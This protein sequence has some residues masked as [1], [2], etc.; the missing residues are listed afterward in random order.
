MSKTILLIDASH[1]LFRA[2][3][4]LP[5]LNTKSGHPTGATRGFLSMLRALRRDVPTDYVAC[6]FDPKGKTF[7]SDIYPDYKA[8]R[9]E[10]PEDL[11]LQI[12]DVFDAVRKQGIPLIQVNGIEADDTIGTIAKSAGE[13]GCK[14]VIATGDKDYAQLVTQDVVLINTMGA[15]N[16]W[17]DIEGVKEKFG[18]PPKQIIDYLALMGDKIDNVPGVPK[19]GKKTA[20][21]WLEEYGSLENIIEN[22]AAVKGKIG[23]NLRDS[24]AFLPV[25]KALVTIKQD[26]DISSQVNSLEDLKIKDPDVAALK[27]LYERLEFRAFLKDLKDE[28]KSGS[29]KTD[30]KKSEEDA[31]DG[32]DLFSNSE[33][34]EVQLAEFSQQTIE[35]PDEAK[36]LVEEI[37]S[38]SKEGKLP[39]LFV[40]ADFKDF[41]YTLRGIA[42]GWNTGKNWFVPVSTNWVD[43]QGIT[44][45]EFTQIFGSWLS[46]PAFEKSCYDTK[47]IAHVLADIGIEFNGI[48]EDV[49]LQNYVLEAHRTHYI[50]KLSY[51]WLKFELQAEEVLLGKGVKKKTFSEVDILSCAKFAMERSYVGAHLSDLFC[52][53]IEKDPNLQ[54]IYREIEM[55]TSRV[56]FRMEQNGVLIDKQLLAKQTAELQ[57]K[58][59]ELSKK[60]ETIAGEKFNLASPKQ[61]GEILFE[62]LGV[63]MNG[64]PS[65]K[66]ASGNYS[67]SEEVLSELA[68]DYPLAKIALEYR[69]LTK[70]ISTY[71]EK[72]PTQI[73]PRDGRVHTTFEQAV[74]VTGRLS[75]TNPNL[76]NI[77]VRTPEGRRVREAFIAGPGKK[78]ISAD[79][80]QIELRI[81]AHLSGDK[82]FTEAFKKN[83]DIH[84]AT[85][86]E[87][88]SEPLE[89]VTPD[90]RR[91]AKV[92]NFGLIYGMS[93]FGLAKNLNIDRHDAKNYIA[94]YFQRYPG[95]SKYM[96][97]T[98]QHALEKGYIQTVFGRRLEIPE[99]QASGARKAAA[100]RAAINAP[101]QGT[102]ADLIKMAMIAVQDWLQKENLE[103][104]LILQ[105]HDELILEVPDKEVEVVK[106]RLPEIMSSVAELHVPLIAEVGVGE[107][108]EAA[109]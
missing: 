55:P 6:V 32:L 4:A 45:E 95:V 99:L 44:P 89:A 75:S 41:T 31:S 91:I 85:A 49:L 72:L 28:S 5:P 108:W 56:L 48:K 68:L 73:S 104:K 10:T 79:Y 57:A 42:V 52:G 38:Q 62:K 71:T 102:A 27:E 80:S 106:K 93:A 30:S 98:R 20:S 24:L 65:K 82:G 18:V 19:C 90:Q 84:R 60:A 83:Q 94:R 11:K 61:L 39:F 26:A 22:A 14:V 67:T 70:L 66:T 16:T 86:A 107:N 21:K 37:C 78:I 58:A 40:L 17:L 69:A 50:E 34:K 63:L 23:D 76:Q 109:H 13:A 105:V 96:E 53:L 8:N 74:A 43:P 54:K 77:P 81:M 92:I 87:V 101:M 1:F 33:E 9:E 100:E 46:D 64:K 51:N 59:S 35:S 7:R 88:F 97:D 15:E 36:H 12:P 29:I 103:S 47:Y 2:F 25:A 3:F